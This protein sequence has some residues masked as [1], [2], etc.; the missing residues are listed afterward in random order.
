[1]LRGLY[2]AQSQYFFFKENVIVIILNNTCLQTLYKLLLEL[3][4][5]Y[6]LAK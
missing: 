2:C 5:L 6:S 1:M 4:R 3:L